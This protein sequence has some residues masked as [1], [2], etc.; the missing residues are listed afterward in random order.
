MFFESFPE[1]QVSWGIILWV[2]AVVTMI[3]GNVAALVQENIKR[4]LAYSSIAHAGYLLIGMV[5][6]QEAGMSGMLYY[7]LA[8]T[9]TNLGA[10]AVVALVGCLGSRLGGWRLAA[11]MAGFVLFIAFA[12]YW[13]RA[14][15]TTYMVFVAVVVCVILGVSLGIWAAARDWRTRL[16]QLL[17][18]SFQTF[19][20]FIYLI[21]VIMLFQVGDVAAITAIVIYAGIPATRYTM[22]GLRGVAPQTVEAAITSGCTP[23]QLLFKVRLPLAGGPAV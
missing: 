13:P 23:A 6:G 8:Y 2:L 22:F 9:F 14:L 19:P 18:D 10:F 3:V 12:G 16:V 5:A 20:S 11:T 7:L 15:I 21:P 17:C 4:M 1:A